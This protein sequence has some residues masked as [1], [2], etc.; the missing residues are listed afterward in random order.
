[1]GIKNKVTEIYYKS[2]Y[3]PI[4]TYGATV[5]YDK[6]NHTHVNRQ[7][8]SIQ[9]HLLLISTRACRT[10]STVAMQVAAHK[11]PLDLE[12]TRKGIIH[13]V[14][15][16]RFVE[17]DTYRYVPPDDPLLVVDLKQEKKN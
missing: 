2:V 11:L 8:K 5:W 14:R 7:L 10:T 15:R 6:V 17:W 16:K 9:R 3:L 12:V 1:L 13:K 4:I